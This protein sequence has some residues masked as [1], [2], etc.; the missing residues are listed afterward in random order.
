MITLAYGLP[1]TGKTTLLHDLIR[2]QTKTQR[3]F[4]VDHANE[5]ADGSAP[6]WRGAAPELTVYDDVR[7]IP[8][9]F[10]ETGVFVFQNMESLT[11]AQLVTQHGNA[12]F[13]DDEI[14]FIARKKGWDESPLRQIVHKGRHLK[15]ELGEV[16]EAHIYGACRRPQSLHNDLS[17]MA[18]QVFIFQVQGTRTLQR[19][20]S[21]S[22]IEDGEWERI[23]TLPK[24]HFRHYPSGK[25]LRIKEITGPDKPADGRIESNK[26]HENHEEVGGE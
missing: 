5:W 15:N 3:F 10:P 14:D 19:L 16:T 8:D 2:K 13:V 11:V 21:D 18:D 17:E 24:F 20:E 26:K 23:R 25:W 12:V 6:H 22:M 9:E 1:G 7:L 4:I